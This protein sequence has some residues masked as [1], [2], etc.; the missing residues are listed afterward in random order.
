MTASLAPLLAAASAASG[1]LALLGWARYLRLRHGLH[2]RLHG[3]GPRLARMLLP[4]WLDRLDATRP[5]RLLTAALADAGLRLRPSAALALAL[6]TLGLGLRLAAWLTGFPSLLLLPFCG[7]AALHG[8]KRLLRHLWEQS[9]VAA[10]VQ[11][12]EACR[13]LSGAL[14]AGLSVP[15]GLGVV[16]AQLP[17]PAGAHFRRLCGE[18]ALGVPL[19]G[20]LADLCRR[21]PSRALR[22]FALAIALNRRMGGD[23]PSA[24]AQLGR[25]LAERQQVQAAVAA[26]TA[27]PRFVAVLLPVMPLAIAVLLNALI[28][29]F[30]RPL[31]TPWGLLLLAV[32]TVLQWIGLAA[33]RRVTRI[34]L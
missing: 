9:A 16:A 8:G 22:L 1:V 6:L 20:A 17:P 33:V 12:V 26:A 14:R 28:P 15:Q 31:F 21:L 18:L 29:G 24:L 30:L 4:A 2:L 34:P 32:C 27:E 13:L 19:E 10:E 3:S 25:T 23:L 7:A 11:L 5:L